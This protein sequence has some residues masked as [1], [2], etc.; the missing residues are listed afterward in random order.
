MKKED[1][2]G[3][4]YRFMIPFADRVDLARRVLLMYNGYLMA[5]GQKNVI[6]QRH[7]NL[8]AYYFVF[9]YSYETKKKFSYL[10]STN[11]NYISVLDTELKR[12]G[13]LVDRDGNCKTRSL[14]QDIENL[15]RLYILEGEKDINGIVAL[16]YRDE[17]CVEVQEKREEKTDIV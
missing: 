5:I 9:G 4:V 17:T 6:E 7:F 11:M 8:L 13:I 1:K 15:R 12:K 2:P 10:F 14:C 3:K 16:F